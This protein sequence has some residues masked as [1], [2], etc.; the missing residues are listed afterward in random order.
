[1]FC[2]G[3]KG[4]TSHKQMKSPFATKLTSEDQI[5]TCQQQEQ[6]FLCLY[7]FKPITVTLGSSKPRVQAGAVYTLRSDD[8]GFTQ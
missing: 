3:Q 8:F 2:G 7:S 6:T 4:V 1:M 5:K